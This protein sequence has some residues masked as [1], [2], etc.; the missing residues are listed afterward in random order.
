MT[1]NDKKFLK[2]L[3]QDENDIKSISKEMNISYL[4]TKILLNRG[5][6]N[7]KDIEK[8]LNPTYD[9]F[10][11]PFLLNDMKLASKRIM[12]AIELDEKIWIYG[13]YDV[14]G[15]T[16]TSLLVNFFSQIGIKV[17]FYIPN[18]HSEG[19]GL[20]KSAI[21]YIKMQ[22]G[23]LII[24]V[25]CGI[26]SISEADYANEIGIDMIITDHHTPS[27]SL[28][29]AIAVINPSRHDSTYPF[30]KLA[31]VGVAFKL[32]QAVSFEFEIEVDYLSLLPIVAIGTVADIV[33]LIDE[34]RLIVKK[35]LDLIKETSNLGIKSL[36]EVTGL[37]NKKVTSGHVGFIIGPRINAA[38]RMESASLGVELFT[39]TDYE[40]ALEI[41]K[42]LDEENKNRQR[43][44]AEILEKAEK[45]VKKHDM[46]NDNIIVLASK[47]WHSGVIGIVSSRITEKYHR[48][49]IL[50]SID[51]KGIGKASAR[52][53]GPLNIYDALKEC[54]DLFLGFG[55]HSQA[56]GLSI[57]QENITLFK[58]KI[59]NIVGNML[60]DEDFIKEVKI[61]AIVEAEDISISTVNILENLSPFGMGN[62]SPVFLF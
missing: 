60:D 44:E 30:K 57:E 59:N 39:S 4:I 62:S 46:A 53:I 25:D 52:S 18:R 19:Y 7:K 32:V 22:K 6:K 49:S 12:E 50:I 43:V 21:D 5:I 56:A 15:V 61:D 40:K 28:P 1:N 51:D 8:F 20:N 33:D 9:D 48:P 2:V 31:G 45:M 35:G 54:K 29:K 11:D 10:H 47:D 58:E 34:N 27:E 26:T 3:N 16:S 37:D 55:G 17:Q 36:I 23:N 41:S 13:D 42:K 14:D 24:T 38:G